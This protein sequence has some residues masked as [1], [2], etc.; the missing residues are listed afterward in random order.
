MAKLG[1]E[2]SDRLVKP[3]MDAEV[4]D[5]VLTK[6]MPEDKDSEICQL[7]TEHLK[8][9]GYLTLE[10]QTSQLAE[11]YRIIKRPI[12]KNAFGKMSSTIERPNLIMLT[13]ALPGEGK[14]FSA[15]NLAL[16]IALEKDTT[17]LLVDCDVVNPRLTKLHGLEGKP[18]LIDL[19]DDPS[20]DL[21]DVIVNTN[22]PNFRILPAGKA[23]NYST[24]LLS[25]AEMERVAIELSERY[26]DRIVIFDAPP[27]LL[28]TQAKVLSNIVGQIIIV[29]AAGRT[30]KKA[31]KEVISELDKSKVSGLLLNACGPKAAQYKGGYS[32]GYEYK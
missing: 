6:A 4:D 32:A 21:R 5:V 15:I 3:I 14:T 18:G 30:P 20:C 19:L 23:H 12:L 1:K 13:S 11:E 27:I 2:S 31:V 29:V 16:S 8:Q 26:K 9:Y 28:T 10:T 17:V 22:I 7:D 25:S 24:E